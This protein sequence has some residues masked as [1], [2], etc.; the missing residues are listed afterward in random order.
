MLDDILHYLE[1]VTQPESMGPEFSR[2]MQ[3]VIELEE[4]IQKVLSLDF[5]DAFSEAEGEL[6]RFERR[7]CFSRGFRLGVQLM[8]AAGR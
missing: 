1:S 8:L 2:L 4:P 5:L 6:M 7:E 3:Q